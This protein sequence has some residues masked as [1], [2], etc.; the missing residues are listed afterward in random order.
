MESNELLCDSIIEHIHIQSCSKNALDEKRAKVGY[1]R[2]E[3][4]KYF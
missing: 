2:G 1:L 3:N 4:L